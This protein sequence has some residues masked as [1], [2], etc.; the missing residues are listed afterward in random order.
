MSSLVYRET[1]RTKIMFVRHSVAQPYYKLLP[2]LKCILISMKI[3]NGTLEHY[4]VTVDE[5]RVLKHTGL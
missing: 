5:A 4:T 1:I 3:T 2:K